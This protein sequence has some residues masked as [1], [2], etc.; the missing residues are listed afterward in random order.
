MTTSRLPFILLLLFVI[1][2]SGR[3]QTPGAFSRTDGSPFD[4]PAPIDFSEGEYTY[5]ITPDGK[6]VVKPR[7]GKSRTLDLRLARGDVLQ[8]Y[9]YHAEYK[10]DLLLI[11]QAGDVEYST[12]FIVRIDLKTL[13]L[14][15]KGSL[16]GFNIGNGLIHEGYV[17]VTAIGFI[18]KVSLESGRFAWKHRNLY[19]RITTAFNSFDVPQV[20]DNTVV[21]KESPNHLRK[22]V[23]QVIVN[24]TTGKILKVDL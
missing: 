18:G 7:N 2:T 13:K 23:A 9:I 15:W 24:R 16:V 4:D 8:D 14:K 20:K 21:F 5:R 17:Y 19:H 3:S 10:G 22:K 12:G 1:T 6:G 11:Y